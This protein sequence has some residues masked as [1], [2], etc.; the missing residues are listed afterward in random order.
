MTWS[1]TFVF[2]RQQNQTGLVFPFCHSVGTYV[3]GQAS[4][5]CSK[6]KIWVSEDK[7]SGGTGK[8][9]RSHHKVF[10]QVDYLPHGDSVKQTLELSPTRMRSLVGVGGPLAPQLA[11]ACA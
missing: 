1:N 9:W 8:E 3:L 2:K 11:P 4:P 10:Y 7:Y 6:T 5:E